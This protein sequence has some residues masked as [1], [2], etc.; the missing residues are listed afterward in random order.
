MRFF[1][2]QVVV[3]G[4]IAS[5]AL[6]GRSD[7]K[8]QEI[9]V[10]REIRDLNEDELNMFITA[11][12]SIM[13][14]ASP[15]TFD[16]FSHLHYINSPK[17]HNTPAFL[18]WHRKF[19]LDVEN[20]IR[21]N[22][23]DFVLP[24]WDWTSEAQ[25]PEL[26]PILSNSYFGS[27]GYGD[28]KCIQDGPFKDFVPHYT[29]YYKGCLARD[30]N[31]NNTYVG[32]TITPFYTQEQTV[33]LLTKHGNFDDFSSRLEA[34][35][36]AYVHN[37]IGGGF[38]TMNSPNDPLFYMHHGFLDKLWA[39]WQNT[40]SNVT[41]P[42]GTIIKPDYLLEP[43]NVTAGSMLYT[44]DDLCYRYANPTAAYANK[45]QEQPQQMNNKLRRRMPS[46]S[47]VA[48]P[49]F[50]A[51]NDET[52]VAP[53]PSTSNNEQAYKPLA[54]D[55]ED[56]TK[57]RAPLPISESW[58]KMN[59]LNITRVREYESE[60]REFIQKLNKIPNYVSPS[61]L[62]NK[63]DSMKK[64]VATGKVKQFSAYVDGKKVVVPVTA[65]SNPTDAVARTRNTLLQSG[66]HILSPNEM[67]ANLQMIIGDGVIKSLDSLL[68]NTPILGGLLNGGLLGGG[69]SDNASNKGLLGTGLL[70]GG[71]ANKSRGSTNADI[72]VDASVE[73]NAKAS[74][75]Y[76]RGQSTDNNKATHS[77]SGLLGGLVKLR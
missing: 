28:N 32:N 6:F 1:I 25:A 59:R 41:H 42:L 2:K 68:G 70:G 14:N 18:A 50:G 53:R 54:M 48:Q 52:P 4:A 29:Q 27:N 8:C 57:L 65:G 20:E 9:R 22:H 24:Y 69:N 5:A 77:S 45:T 16:S 46:Y 60:E 17:A 31:N 55:R 71:N 40:Y 76:G 37:G 64:L 58:C 43:W 67:V 74:T 15:S 62:W 47:A 66:L 38:S 39:D 12:R 26:S 11:L 75:S 23:T 61:A 30:F 10:R 56:L 13:F 73:A 72:N 36:H 49:R 21:K 3:L 34:V 44:V 63:D 51:N 7:A 35:P 33:N 19:I